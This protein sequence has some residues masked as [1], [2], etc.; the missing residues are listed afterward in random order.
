MISLVGARVE[1]SEARKVPS[2]G[3][4]FYYC[5][6]IFL[7]TKDIVSTINLLKK[8]LVLRKI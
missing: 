6:Y 2:C 5:F 8:L 3:V 7:S 1:P 4:T